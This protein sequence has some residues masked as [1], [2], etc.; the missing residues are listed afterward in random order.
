MNEIKT[1]ALFGGSFDPP[2]IGHEAIVKAI[3]NFRDVDKVVIMPTFLNPFKELSHAPSDVRLR[4]LRKIFS[5]FKNVEVSSYEVDQNKKVPT[6]QTVLHLL[7]NYEKIYLIIGADN[8]SS[9]HKWHSFTELKKLVNIVI[10]SR[11][12]IETDDE[13]LKLDI[14]VDISST[15][16]RDKMDVK[17]LPQKCSKEIEKFYKEHNAK[18]N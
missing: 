10:V 12:K 18:Q 2:H 16:L 9:L 3:V 15:S 8:L 13:F 11:D 5:E 14:D 6:I 1:I 7:K 4:W 17:K